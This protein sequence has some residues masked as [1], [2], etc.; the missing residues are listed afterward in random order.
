M[1][2]VAIRRQSSVFQ[3]FQQSGAA[4]IDVLGF[5]QQMLPAILRVLTDLHHGPTCYIASGDI[6]ETWVPC[7]RLREHV[8]AS[9][10]VGALH[11]H[12]DV[13][14]APEEDPNRGGDRQGV[15]SQVVIFKRLGGSEPQWRSARSLES[16]G[17]NARWG[18][19]I[20]DGIT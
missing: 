15:S 11:A 1:I 4:A 12:A 14:M 13:S 16:A 9:P 3:C 17:S 18:S 20:Y 6:Q 10:G 19:I 7:S 5:G 8:P 2:M